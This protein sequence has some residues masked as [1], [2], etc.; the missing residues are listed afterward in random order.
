M[1]IVLHVK[2]PLF[3]SDFNRT[4]I[5]ATVFFSKNTK[6]PNFMKIRPV[7]AQLCNAD[8]RT[9]DMKKLIVSILDFANAPKNSKLSVKHKT[10]FIQG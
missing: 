4:L 8:G 7:G 9:A 6:K 10:Y 3:F 5:F 2:Y 1:Y